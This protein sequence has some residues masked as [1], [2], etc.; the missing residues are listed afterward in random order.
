MERVYYNKIVST[1]GEYSVADIRTVSMQKKVLTYAKTQVVA[2]RL[3]QSDYDVWFA[4]YEE[5]L[6]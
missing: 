2:G 3:D 1:N 6:A 5:A 4:P